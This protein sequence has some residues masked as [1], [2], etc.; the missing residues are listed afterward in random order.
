METLLQV[1]TLL[2]QP[3][4]VLVVLLSAVYG[5]I[6]G[7]MPGLTATM[8]TALLVPFLFFLDPL[9]GLVA[10]ITMEAVAIFAGDIPAV[11]LRI[12]G[13]PSTAAYTDD[14]YELTKQGKGSLVL[15]LDLACSA[16]GGILGA[17]AF[18]VGASWLIHI[19]TS[20]TSF[21]YF[22]LAVMGLSGAALLASGAPLKGT[23]SALF[24]LLLSTVGIDI[25]L[26]YPRFTFGNI[27]LLGGISFIPA[28]IGL[29][30]VS[31]VL[32]QS[33]QPHFTHAPAPVHSNP[34]PGTVLQL[35][36]RY[37]VQL[38][39]G[40]FLGTL[41]G[42]IPGMGADIAAWLSYAIAK[43]FSRERQNFGK[44]SFEPI[45]EAGTANNAALA[46]AWIPALV[47][48]IPGDPVTAIVIGVLMMKGLPPGPLLFQEQETLLNGLRAMFI[49]ANVL[50]LPLGYLAIRLAA[51][52]LRIP[53]NIL[54]PVT[55]LLCAVGA[56]ALENNPFDIGI[57]LVMGV[58]G[59][60]MQSHGFPLAPAVLGLVL[61]P[62]IEE[63]FMISMTKAQGHFREFFSRPVSLLLAAFTL[64]VW[65]LP[66]LASVVRRAPGKPLDATG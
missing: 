3:K 54:M 66:L 36:R 40:G 7:A 15:A 65:S 58:V 51:S 4:V 22:W 28:M 23:M 44:G 53:R 50:M 18:I 8:A 27:N 57:M 1:L 2:F 12:P 61:G 62:L 34:L 60:L 52:L 6:V 48:G 56:Y 31:E 30:G 9:S 10:I 16:I 46:A 59:Y 21:E 14:S 49:L 39:R 43:R 17:L 29:Y 5:L 13:T 64:V 42:A 41:V 63:N 45:V 19:A 47:F 25:T 24:G 38:L 37:K 55:L 32:R 20:F 35:L 33:T 11:L 26:G